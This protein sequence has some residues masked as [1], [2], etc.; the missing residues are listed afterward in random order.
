MKLQKYK[1]YFPAFYPFKMY[2]QLA[3]I[4][5]YFLFLSN[6]HAVTE[7]KYFIENDFQGNSKRDRVMDYLTA[8]I[9]NDI[10]DP[11]VF[12]KQLLN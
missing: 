1:I 6:A 5:L 9:Q 10:T 8:F 11:V 4:C 7:S 3:L 12:E 2:P